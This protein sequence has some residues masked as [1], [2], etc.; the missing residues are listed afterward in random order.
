VFAGFIGHWMSG[1]EHRDAVG[2][3]PV[4]ITRDD[5][6]VERR[7][8]RPVLFDRECHGSGGFTG[9]DY[10][11]SAFRALWQ[12]LRN[13]QQRIGRSERRFEALEQQVSR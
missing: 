9:T 10:E 13:E 8:G 12:M 4:L 11:G 5:Q 7:I 6:A 3:K 1:F 2:E